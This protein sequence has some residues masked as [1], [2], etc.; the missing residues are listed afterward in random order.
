MHALYDQL[1][2]KVELI[3]RTSRDATV[4]EIC[5]DDTAQKLLKLITVVSLAV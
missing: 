1:T 5:R 2:A 4:P 3:H